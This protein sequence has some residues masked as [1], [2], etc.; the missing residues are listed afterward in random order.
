VLVGAAPLARRI[1]AAIARRE[2][3]AAVAVYVLAIALMG[4]SAFASGRLLAAA[5][6]A[7]FLSSDLLLAWNRFVRPVAWARPAIMVTYHLGQ[8][9]LT[10]ALRGG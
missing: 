2:L 1:L 9:A 10:A 8:L 3:R 6:A 7:L 5:G 4:A